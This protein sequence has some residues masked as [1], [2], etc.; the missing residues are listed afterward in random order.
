MDNYFYAH[1]SDKFTFYRIPKE[2]YHPQFKELSDSARLLYGL[3]LDRISLS[4]KNNWIDENNR[5]YIIFT[6]QELEEHTYIGNQKA[7]KLFKE[8]IKFNLL[9]EKRQGL[10]KPNLLYVKQIVISGTCESHTTKKCDN[11]ISKHVKVTHQKIPKSHTTK[12]NKNKTNFNNNDSNNNNEK[13]QEDENAVVLKKE[14]ENILQ[15]P[16]SYPTVLKLLSQKGE[17]IIR[18]YLDN[19]SKFNGSKNNVV[20]YFIDMVTKEYDIPKSVNGKQNKP[21]QSTNFEQRVYDD[22]YF[23]SLYENFR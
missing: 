17:S 14:I 22:D 12:N 2:L 19:W 23:E 8:L 6:R 13:F 16:I 1:E 18:S 5:I 3:L 9:E 7:I 20:G 21:E 10:N 4:R 15:T 11:G